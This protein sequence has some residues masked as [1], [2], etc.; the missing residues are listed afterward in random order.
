MN[1]VKAIK[2]PHNLLMES[3]KKLM[4]TGVKSVESFNEQ[5]VILVTEM[6]E[7]TVK[8]SGLHVGRLNV[9]SGE[10]DINGNICA[11]IYNDDTKKE[12]GFL[13]RIFK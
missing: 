8:G 6:G 3:R 10:I 4:I 7:M 2:Q 13:G 12:S 9:D 1:E 5:T 11:I